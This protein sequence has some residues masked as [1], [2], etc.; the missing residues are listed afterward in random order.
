MMGNDSVRE[1]A[2]VEVSSQEAQ[3]SSGALAVSGNASYS[4]IM[5][6]LFKGKQVD[7]ETMMRV[8]SN[9]PGSMDIRNLKERVTDILKEDDIKKAIDLIVELRNNE[10]LNSLIL[11]IISYQ[12]A[13]HFRNVEGEFKLSDICKAK[14]PNRGDVSVHIGTDFFTAGLKIKRIQIMHDMYQEFIVQFFKNGRDFDDTDVYQMFYGLY[15][16]PDQPITPDNLAETMSKNEAALKKHVNSLMSNADITYK[17]Y[18]PI[19]R[20]AHDMES[21][22]INKNDII[23][24]MLGCLLKDDRN[25]YSIGHFSQDLFQLTEIN[26]ESLLG[27]VRRIIDAM[28]ENRKE[29]FK[30]YCDKYAYNVPKTTE[31]K[32]FFTILSSLLDMLSLVPKEK[33]WEDMK[34]RIETVIDALS[35]P[36]LLQQQAG[37]G[38][39]PEEPFQGSIEEY[40]KI[41]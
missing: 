9:L 36:E 38:Q 32:D 8:I 30:K 5:T 3:L 25:F 37:E 15:K 1:S 40:K 17:R 26:N 31:D 27:P 16:S 2:Q 28:D 14:F 22:G 12:F 13:N 7:V 34:T 20:K 18:L 33:N 19:I 4:E 39:L 41:G 23:A 24:M 11:Q 35:K 10:G 6:T 29:I 21:N